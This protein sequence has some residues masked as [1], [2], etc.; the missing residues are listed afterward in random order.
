MRFSP[1]EPD[2]ATI[3]RRII[4][5]DIDLQPDF[6]RGEVW[7]VSKKQ[8]LIDTVLRGW[9]IPPVLIVSSGV[10]SRQQ[11]LDG[12]Q[13]LASIRDFLNDEFSIDGN[14]AP[15]DQDIKNLHGKRFSD[16]SDVLKRSILRTPVRMYE[17]YDYKPEEPAE[18]FFR[19]NQ[20]TGLTSAEKR[21]AFFGPVRDQV[22][23]L[24]ENFERNE[25]NLKRGL[26]FSNGRMAYD[27]VFARLAFVLESGTLRKKITSNAVNDMYRRSW[28]IDR[29]TLSRMENAMTMI[30]DIFRFAGDAYTSSHGKLNKATLLSW[31]IFFSRFDK[32][33]DAHEATDYFLWFESV[34]FE[35]DLGLGR[36]DSFSGPMPALA[37]V[38]SDRASS[39]VTD[40]SS[41]LMRDFSLW[42]G[43]CFYKK[44]VPMWMGR[45]EEKVEY[46]LGYIEE[47]EYSY[48]NQIFEFME[49]VDWGREI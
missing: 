23:E 33:G 31:L 38:Y 26:G 20:P 16:L 46:F 11:V 22:R 42:M 3:H 2:I 29:K 10:G 49:G 30:I 25:R 18:I 43:W 15:L 48:E 27:D 13:R 45:W 34:I 39:R 41:V 44:S 5:G 40:V 12:Q 6:Q 7:T 32:I 47:P 24:V 28:P 8:R 19:L 35:A 21:N 36:L 9:V 4:E 14:V 1:A 37:A 17:I